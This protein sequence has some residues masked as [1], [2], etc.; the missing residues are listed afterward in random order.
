MYF[1]DPGVP[2]SLTRDDTSDTTKLV[3][4]WTAP[5]VGGA[6]GYKVTIPDVASTSITVVTA[7]RKATIVGLKAGTQYA[8]SVVAVLDGRDSGPRTEQ[9]YTSMCHVLCMQAILQWLHR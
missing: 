8:V 1:S 5:A 4:K 2:V 7:E 9:F 3:V 6:T